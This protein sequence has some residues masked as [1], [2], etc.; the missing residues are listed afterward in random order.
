[1][2]RYA[3][4][5][6]DA[7]RA[8]N[9]LRDVARASVR[10]HIAAVAIDLFAERGFDR[11]TVE[12]I[13]DAAGISARTFHRY[14]PAK[15]DAVTGDPTPW[16]ELIRDDFAARSAQTPVWTA[17]H[18]SFDALLAAGGHEGEE[19]KRGLRV[20]DSTASLRARHLE[21]H[22]LW[23]SMLTPL[24]EVRLRGGERP[25]R[26]RVIA[27]AAIACFDS[28]LSAWSAA[29]EV[30]SPRELLQIAFDQLDA[31]SASGS[32]RA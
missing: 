21:K 31:T 1:M 8:P 19:H 5:V 25:L 27:R 6:T 14:F 20:L 29:D 7:T 3:Q 16:G 9:A 23:E 12:D 13:A 10:A 17:L 26:A 4:V 15:E 2:S 11:V 22:L 28:A 24:I 32:D 30:R 18:A